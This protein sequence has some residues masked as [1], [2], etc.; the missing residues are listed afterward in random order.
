MKPGIQL[1]FATR[2]IHSIKVLIL[3]KVN[4]IVCVKRVL[5]VVTETS[6]KNLG[7]AGS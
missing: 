5:A 2:I 3:H 7:S 1:I 6:I 4:N